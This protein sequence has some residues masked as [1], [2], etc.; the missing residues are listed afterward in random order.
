MNDNYE[1]KRVCDNRVDDTAETIAEARTKL[2]HLV[3][4][5]PWRYFLQYPKR[6]ITGTT[7]R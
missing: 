5:K 4:S 7:Q 2:E 1:I 6:I 3:D